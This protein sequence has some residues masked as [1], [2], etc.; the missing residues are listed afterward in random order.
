MIFGCLVL[1]EY[2]Y[3]HGGCETTYVG[4]ICVDLHPAYLSDCST[5]AQVESINVVK[6][7]NKIVN[8]SDFRVPIPTH[9]HI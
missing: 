8:S 6:Y 7:I 9:I 4:G 1:H 3:D 2:T 5:L